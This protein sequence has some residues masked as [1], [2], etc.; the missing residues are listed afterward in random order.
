LAAAAAAAAAAGRGVGGVGGFG[1]GGVGGMGS[2]G[3]VGPIGANI[4]GMTSP[5][6]GALGDDT[7]AALGAG[8]PPAG[9]VG[10]GTKD[11]YGRTGVGGLH[12]LP[13]GVRLVIT[14]TILAVIN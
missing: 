9:K 1:V 7:S 14:R 8:K 11:I 6:G 12:S 4:T 3:G 5:I 13:G 2:V 10:K